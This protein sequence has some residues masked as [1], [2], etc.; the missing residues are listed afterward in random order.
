MKRALKIILI[1]LLIIALILLGAWFRAR[2]QSTDEGR[3]APTFREFLGLGSRAPST[4][5]D[6]GG[7]TP[8]GPSQGGRET[9]GTETPSET[10]ATG[11]VAVSQ[12]TSGPLTPAQ[13]TVTGSGNIIGNGTSG[14]GA[15]SGNGTSGTGSTP[16]APQ[17]PTASATAGPACSDEDLNIE[18]TAEEIARLTALQN[19][20]YAVAGSLN[21]D[22]DIQREAANYTSYKAKADQIA[23]LYNYCVAVA[24]RITAPAFRA[25][26]ATPFWRNTSQDGVGYIPGATGGPTALSGVFNGGALDPREV[27]GTQAI[28]QRIFKVNLW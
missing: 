3:P 6:G 8:D 18:F 7:L 28:I 5:T 2:R 24:P 25:R 1:L 4:S 10:P 22:A 14:S 23:E 17:A 13:G 11:G 27:S 12:F 9:P 16:S 21:S 19:R 26:T 15:S 20:F